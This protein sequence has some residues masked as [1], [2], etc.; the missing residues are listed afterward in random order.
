MELC[1]NCIVQNFKVHVLIGNSISNPNSAS[2]TV[3]LVKTNFYLHPLSALV[4]PKIEDS[5]LRGAA[6]A[7]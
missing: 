2:F 3:S 6:Y 4:F 5:S 7:S 1:L